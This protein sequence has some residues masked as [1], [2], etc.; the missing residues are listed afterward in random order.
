MYVPV[1][2]RAMR[3][4]RS[5]TGV[6]RRH[7]QLAKPTS[8]GAISTIIRPSAHREARKPESVPAEP[9]NL[10]IRRHLQVLGKRSAR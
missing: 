5:G 1:S 4:T 6:Q 8:E 10:L 7:P 3:W 9:P 2:I